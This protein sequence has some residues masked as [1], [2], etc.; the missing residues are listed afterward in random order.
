MAG[1]NTTIS[2]IQPMAGNLRIQTAVYGSVVQVMYGRNRVSGNLSWY[3]AFAAVPH[4]STQTSGGKG[5]GKVTQS[6][7]DFTYTAA[8]IMILG[9]GYVG[10]ITSVWKGKIKFVGVPTNSTPVTRTTTFTV[11]STAPI[12]VPAVVADGSGFTA[13][14]SVTNNAVPTQGIYDGNWGNN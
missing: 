13:N 11:G 10:R 1:K 3:G 7:T 9:E 4:T 2:T 5:G 12:N 6:Q 14:V 8:L